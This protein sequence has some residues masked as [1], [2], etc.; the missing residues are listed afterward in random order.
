M[1][2]IDDVARAVA[3]DLS[4]EFEQRLRSELAGRD[5]EWLIDELVRLTLSRHGFDDLDLDAA[6]AAVLREQRL[7]RV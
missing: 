4:P 3:R 1:G 2:T 5:R 7:Q 6:A